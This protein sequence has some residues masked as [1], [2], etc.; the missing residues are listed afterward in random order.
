M[1]ILQ[2]CHQRRR[3]SN[4]VITDMC[5]CRAFKAIHQL[6]NPENQGPP[7][8]PVLRTPTKTFLSN[9]CHI[10]RQECQY[11]LGIILGMVYTSSP[12]LRYRR[13]PLRW[14]RLHGHN[15]RAP[16]K[17]KI[18]SSPEAKV[19]TRQRVARSRARETASD[20]SRYRDNEGARYSGELSER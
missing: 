15:N 12:A 5:L 18:K 14:I 13:P 2:R 19:A 4:Q 20:T 6:L 8:T 9:N 7:N 3:R 1:I 11:R 16:K 10:S 17:A